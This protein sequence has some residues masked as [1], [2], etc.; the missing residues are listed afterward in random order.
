[1]DDDFDDELMDIDDNVE[2]NLDQPS[3][4]GVEEV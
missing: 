2:F 3:S 1:M 4:T